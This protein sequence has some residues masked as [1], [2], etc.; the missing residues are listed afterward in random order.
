MTFQTSEL[1]QYEINTQLLLDKAYLENQT[2]NTLFEKESLRFNRYT[3]YA[4]NLCLDFSKNW[5]NPDIFEHLI[6]LAKEAKVE[7]AIDDLLNGQPINFTESRAALHTALRTPLNTKSSI[8]ETVTHMQHR[9]KHL[10]HQVREKTWLGFSNKPIQHIVNIGIG[11]SYLGIKAALDALKPYQSPDL[12]LHFVVNIDPQDWAC[13]QKLIDPE[14]TLFIIASKSFSTLETLKNAELAKTWMLEQGMPSHAVS[15]HFVAISNQDEKAIQFGI[16]RTNIF[17][18]PDWVGGRYSLWSTMGLMIAL[19][20]GYDSFE[21]LLQ[22]ASEMDQHFK[23]TPLSDNMPVILAVLGIWYHNYFQAESYAVLPYDSSLS[24]FVDHLQQMDME[25]NGKSISKQHQ[26]L[27]YHT[28]PIIWGGVGTNGQHAYHQ[29]LHQGTRLVPVDFIVPLTSHYEPKCQ[30]TH[31]VMHAFAQSQAL[32][33]GRSRQQLQTQNPKQS[34]AVILHKIVPG[35]R[36]SNTITFEKLTPETLGALIAL[37]EH[38]VFVQGVIWNINSFD[39][40][41][42]ELGKQLSD[43]LYQ[44][45]SNPDILKDQDES[46]V[47][48]IN[49]FKKTD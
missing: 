16:D 24:M 48:L 27:T 18:I 7:S 29:L 9:M 1:T 4:A 13:V 8:Q 44:S 41:G 19:S 35:N 17:S 5:I 30:H 38:K 6:Q 32:M 34:D 39:Q 37:Y 45:L 23:K 25:S 49:Q 12:S 26:P 40:W 43:I 14:T 15:Q 47:G 33:Q 10:T 3:R 21:K 22:G 42:V 36:P 31:L 28:A 46:T 20:I 2:L 11:G